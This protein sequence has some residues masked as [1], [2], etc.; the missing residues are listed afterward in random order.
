MF[1][2]I[3]EEQGEIIKINK[4]K[5]SFELKVKCKKVLEN[6]VIGDSIAVNGICLTVTQI[7]DSSFTADVMAET[8]RK[9]NFDSIK[10]GTVVNLERALTLNSR[11]GGH[12]VSG[13]VDGLGEIREITKEENAY[14]YTIITKPS[15]I[16]YVILKGSV[17]INGISLTV[18]EVGRDYFKV[19]II[20]HTRAHTNLEKIKKGDKINIENDVIGKYVER[21]TNSKLLDGEKTSKIDENFLFKNGFMEGNV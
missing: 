14:W 5:V 13:H 18:A 12:M 21:F 8:Y 9:T 10:I 6:T 16:R 20:P 17:A 19:S 3:I 1:T 15:I 7:E 2:G 4:L 11:L